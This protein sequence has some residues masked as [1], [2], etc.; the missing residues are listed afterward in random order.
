MNSESEEAQRLER[1]MQKLEVEVNQ[2]QP[3]QTHFEAS[4]AIQSL[5]TQFLSWYQ[6]LPQIGQVAVIGGG[7]LI[8]LSALSIV[9]QLIRL[10]FSL[11][12]L[13]VILYLGYKFF[14]VPQSSQDK[15]S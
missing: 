2:Q 7:I 11:A 1:Q 10:A 9:F 5:Y 12:V 15:D 14:L 8:G 4:P 3:L 13:G 6:R